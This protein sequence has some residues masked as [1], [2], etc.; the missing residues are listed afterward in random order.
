MSTKG[1][2]V[3]AGHLC[4]DMYP[5]F[6]QGATRP[7]SDILRPG[8]LVNMERMSFST[9]G[10]VANTGIAL[11]VFGCD[12]VSVAK[13][14]DDPIG[15]LVLKILARY[16]NDEGIRVSSGEATSYTVV[17][18]APGVD[19]VFL[20]C[21]GTNDTFTS[22]DVDFGLVS[23]ARI[24][25]FGYPPLMRRMFED[26]GGELETILRRVRESGVT[27]SLDM[28]LPDQTA[29]AGKADWPSILARALAHTDIFVPSIEEAFCCLHPAEYALRKAER[30][31]EDM[32]G[33]FGVE[34]FRRLGG[35]LVGMGCGLVALK[36]GP[37]GW[38]L[39]TAARSRIERLGAVAPSAP[40]EW[41]DREVWC[42]AYRVTD[43]A[44]T[45][46]SGDA[47]IAGFLT[48]LLRGNGLE[49]CLHHANCAGAQNLSALD[50]VSGLKSWDAVEADSKRLPLVEMSF[51]A[52]T[53][54]RYVA[55]RGVWERRRGQG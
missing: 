49:E 41:A 1:E 22:A 3:V 38:Y 28:A 25:H 36:A 8:A 23:R 17:L 26:G 53:E 46:G 55:D 39:R 18:A 9:G 44:S 32:A 5:G 40:G 33:V 50:T 4:L 12:V 13:V 47:S 2:I 34:D 6:P 52:G 27:T 14:G 30:P 20:H 51:L 42:P 24:F 54:W 29:P 35:E 11:R 37:R 10:A 15:D 21:T 43:I 45:A 48:S 31:G 16:G 19:R 7:L